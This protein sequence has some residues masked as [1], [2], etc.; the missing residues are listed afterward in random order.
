MCLVRLRTDDN[1]GKCENETTTRSLNG[2]SCNHHVHTD[3]VLC[4]ACQA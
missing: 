1:F 4:T 2:T 3:N